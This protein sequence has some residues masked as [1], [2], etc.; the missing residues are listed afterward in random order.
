MT[1]SGSTS[2]LLKR[3]RLLLWSAVGVTALGCGFAATAPGD[4][5]NPV[6]G[7]GAGGGGSMM[8]NNAGSGGQPPVNPAGG[9]GPIMPNAGAGGVV[10]PGGG[11]GGGGPVNPGGADAGGA[12]GSAPVMGVTFKNYEVT[13]SW[14]ELK[15]VHPTTG[16]ELPSAPGALTYTKIT[17]HDRHLAESCSIA[18]YNNDGIPDV[19]SGRRWF[20]GPAFTTPHIF[21]GGHDDLPREG[22]GEELVTGVSDDWADY[23]WDV[24]GDGYADIINIASSDANTPVSPQP[25]PQTNATAVWYENPGA[26]LAGDPMWIAHTMHADVRHEQHGMLDAD[27]DGKPEIYGACKGCD[28]Q[29]RKGYYAANWADPNGTWTFHAVSAEVEFPFGGTGW[30]HGLGAG[31]VNGDGKP[32]LL[33]RNGVWLQQPDG[34][35]N[36]NICPGAGC[37]WINTLLYDENPAP[38]KGGSHMFAYDVDGDGDNDIFSSEAA[39]GYGL[40]WWEQTADLGLTRHYMMQGPEQMAMYGVAFSQSHAAQAIDMDGDGIRDIVTGKMRFAHPDGYGDPDLRGAPVLYV[41][42]TVRDTPGTSGAAHFEPVL[43]DSEVGVGRQLA[44][45]QINAHEDGIMD[46]CIGSKVGLYVF[47]GQ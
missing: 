19:S 25:Q 4:G 40:A 46:I 37:G 39:H 45:G 8:N 41:F 20:E 31:D 24:N 6:T 2:F 12:G 16:A 36:A 26:N 9:S 21:R 33:D 27:G 43:V 30:M 5:S 47:L 23:P 32:D 44:V 1:T 18:D 15:A 35:F 28:P 11:A 42:R 10:T 22:A 29:N 38:E 13:G 3:S 17:V 14:P 7:G 34:S